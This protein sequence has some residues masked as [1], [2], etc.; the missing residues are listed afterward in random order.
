MTPSQALWRS[1]R[2]HRP[3]CGRRSRDGPS[4]ALS[5]PWF[6]SQRN[7]T[8]STLADLKNG[9]GKRPAPGDAGLSPV[10]GGSQ[11]ARAAVA[12]VFANATNKRSKVEP[13]VYGVRAKDKD[14]F[15]VPKDKFAVAQ[16]LDGDEELKAEKER[17]KG[18]AKARLPDRQPTTASNKRP[19]PVK[20]TSQQAA[21]EKDA[22]RLK[23]QKEEAKRKK[24]QI[25]Q[26]TAQ[27]RLKYRNAI[28]SFVFFFDRVDPAVEAQLSKEVEKWGAV[29]LSVSRAFDTQMT[30]WTLHSGTAASGS[31][32]LQSRHPRHYLPTRPF[33]FSSWHRIQRQ[34]FSCRRPPRITLQTPYDVSCEREHH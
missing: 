1:R 25:K 17:A 27:W 2:P 16:G 13:F 19:K 29:R 33:A 20:S 30:D 10:V 14:G 7:A 15:A 22:A 5:D 23:Q 9:N 26:E 32:L 31:V 8:I 11:A 4:L 18:K 12:T 3:P 6:R 28:K 21:A 24:E 34:P